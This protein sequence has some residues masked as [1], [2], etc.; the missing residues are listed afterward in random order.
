MNCVL[1]YFTSYSDP[2]GTSDP[3]S[4]HSAGRLARG[5]YDGLRRFGEVRYFHGESP[6]DGL[7]ADLYV[8]HFWSFAEF[9]RRNSF[10][11]KVA[12][13]SVSDPDKTLNLMQTLGTRFDVPVPT[14]DH[15]P[16]GFDHEAT[17][18]AADLVLLIGNSYTLETF[19]EKWRH[20][21]RP[22]N[23]GPDARLFDRFDDTPPRNEFC[24]V[25]TY[26]GL[27]KG[28]LDVLRT[29][30]AIP[31][32]LGRLHAV[33]R[34]YPPWDRLLDDH[35]TGNIVRHGWIDSASEDYV[36]LLKSCKFAHFPTYSEG[37]AG[38]LLE[39]L[40]AGCVP[41]TTRASGIDDEVLDRCIVVEPLNID[42]QRDAILDA[43]AWPE[44]RFAEHRAR[45]R[46]IVRRRQ[47]WETFDIGLESA[48]GPL[49]AQLS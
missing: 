11:R 18:E 9:C 42:Q 34:L 43:L 8:G 25:A 2:N 45:L 33:G 49:V 6:P 28:F 47:T 7:S 26:C 20:K 35:D 32:G 23:Y 39:M 22:L 16:P 41:V 10:R 4:N 21:I 1:S 30:R 48:L 13:Y 24:Y 17:M 15:P 3:F 14:W 38:S 5:L 27:R 44:E 29:W 40:Y 19:P 31:A 36:R 46:E 12:F 37:Q